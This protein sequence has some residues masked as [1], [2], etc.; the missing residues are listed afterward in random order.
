MQDALSYNDKM[1]IERAARSPVSFTHAIDLAGKTTTKVVRSTMS[2]RWQKDYHR[3][4]LIGFVG[5]AVTGCG[6]H[7]E[8]PEHT[9]TYRTTS[10][11][12]AAVGLH[13]P[14]KPRVNGSTAYTDAELEADGIL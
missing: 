11:G 8:P 14:E 10:L 7:G 9:V 4:A 1:L 5:E 6:G 12:R 3:L 2:P 13:E